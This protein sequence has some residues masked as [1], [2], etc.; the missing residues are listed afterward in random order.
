M[1][2]QNK[3]NPGMYTQAGRLA[4][5]DT[6]RELKKQR[7]AATPGSDARGAREAQPQKAAPSRVTEKDKPDETEDAHK[8]N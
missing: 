7:E 5:D 6:A 8:K 1:S 2:K 4:P 3:V